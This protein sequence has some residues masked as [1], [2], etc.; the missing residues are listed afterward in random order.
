[1]NCDF[2]GKSLKY[3]D[4]IV[5]YNFLSPKGYN[6]YHKKCWERK[7]KKQPPLIKATNKS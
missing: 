6:I 4:S 5:Y 7:E 2:C 3:S 1:M